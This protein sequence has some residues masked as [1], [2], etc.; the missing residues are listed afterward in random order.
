[1]ATARN[2]RNSHFLGAK[3]RALRKQ[4]HMTLDELS[5]RCIQ[6]DAQVGPSVYAGTLS[7]WFGM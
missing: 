4:N 3:L 1:M 7:G 5:M 6:V 2:I